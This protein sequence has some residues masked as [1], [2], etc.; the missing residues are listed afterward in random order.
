MERIQKYGLE[1]YEKTVSL[2]YY[3]KLEGRDNLR[4]IREEPGNPCVLYFNHTATDDPFLIVDVLQKENLNSLRN[5]VIPVSEYYSQFKNHPPYALAVRLGRFAGI[6]MPEIVQSYRRRGSEENTEL[7][8]KANTLNLQLARLLK[9]ELAGGSHVIISPE[10]HRSEKGTLLPAESGIG[11]I[12]TMMNNLK[13]EAKIGN[14]YFIPWSIIFENP[15]GNGLYFNPFNKAK[16]NLV[17]GRALE[18]ESIIKESSLFGEKSQLARVSSHILM[19]HLAEQLPDKMQDVYNK[20]LFE[21]T[22][23]GRFEQRIN[24]KGE[25]Y[26]YDKMTNSVH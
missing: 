14:G 5:V 16:V 15:K 19:R 7:D 13:K 12:I 17:I 26:V 18:V 8:G 9:K 6:T 11:L 10:G 21:D 2:G 22:L 23:K 1:F 24:E 4:V 20:S 3:I 25:V